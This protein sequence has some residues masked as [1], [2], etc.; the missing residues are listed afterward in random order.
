VDQLDV[1][2]LLQPLRDLSRRVVVAHPSE[3][4]AGLQLS[5]EAATRY[6]IRNRLKG[7]I[8][9]AESCMLPRQHTQPSPYRTS[10]RS[11]VTQLLSPTYSGSWGESPQHPRRGASSFSASPTANPV[12]T[13]KRRGWF[14][15]FHNR[16]W[17]APGYDRRPPGDIADEHRGND[18][19]L[20][21]EV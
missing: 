21:R 12:G 11:G 5:C 1:S 8:V 6:R 3:L 7:F 18:A 9:F 4:S 15:V 20:G 2:G 13:R 19:G 17:L 14:V 16:V 10:V